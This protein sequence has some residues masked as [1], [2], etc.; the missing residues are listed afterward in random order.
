[1]AQTQNNQPNTST[2]MLIVALLLLFACLVL[3]FI[4]LVFDHLAIL[5]PAA[6]LILATL[7]VLASFLQLW[8]LS[9]LKSSISHINLLR[10]PS[11]PIMLVR[12]VALFVLLLSIVN[13]TLLL[14]T[15]QAGAAPIVLYLRQGGILSQTAGSSA[16]SQSILSA[17]NGHY[18][19]TPNNP[20]IYQIQDINATYVPTKKTAFQLYLDA[21]SNIGDGVQVQI[22]YD[23]RGTGIATRTETYHFFATNDV[24]NWE[25][26]TQIS[27]GG[28]QEATGTLTN[29]VNGTVIVKIW[30]AIGRSS[31]IL[32]TDASLADGQQSEV[33]IP[34]YQ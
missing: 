33:I 18:I 24:P 5:Y 3:G 7:G 1:M 20:I 22:I 17:E 31:P 34:F 9:S 30:S 32:R 15:T 8:P 11:F 27:F 26:Y 2:S 6:S 4:G 28:L 25:D 10:S 12:I 21:G 29:M 19:N 13:M 23:C 16:I 14:R